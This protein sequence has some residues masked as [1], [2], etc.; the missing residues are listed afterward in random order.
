MG[1]HKNPRYNRKRLVVAGTAAVTVFGAMI[2]IGIY[3][4]ALADQPGPAA[5]SQ[6]CLPDPTATVPPSSTTTEPPPSETAPQETAPTETTTGTATETQPTETA[7]D[8]ATDTAAETATDTTTETATDTA[9]E[10]EAPMGLAG[11]RLVELNPGRAAQPTDGEAPAGDAPEDVVG[12]TG[13]QGPAPAEQLP[14][15]PADA[16]MRKFAAPDCTDKLGPFP[17]D[18]VDI[19]RVRPSFTEPRARRGSSNGTFVSRCGRNENNHNNPANFIVAPGNANGAQHT[20]DY[21]GNVSADGFS[22]NE[23]LA[24][25]GTTCKLD[26]RSTYYWPVVRV[27]ERGEKAD[28]VNAH[29]VGTLQ[30][31]AS[32]T[33]QFRGNARGKVV[34]A[35]EFIRII[36]GDAKAAVNGGANGNAKWGCTRFPN[37][38][39]TKY[40]LCPRGSQVLRQLDFPSC[41]DGVNTDSANHRTHIVFPDRNGAC[42]AGTKAVPA[43][44]MTLTY[45]MPR[46]KVYSLDAF[47]DQLHNPVTDHGDFV[48]VMPASLMD[49]VVKCINSGRRC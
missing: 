7:T 24:A 40:T 6:Q 23:S 37:R 14:A 26:D 19:R 34:A 17:Q 49:R 5:A 46:G 47:P 44:R 8:T 13:Y 32:V 43:L 48:N 9:T 22:T 41:W 25:A 2:G 10:S 15:P 1:R 27:R 20:H 12:D 3:G 29:N 35:P 11:D 33:L 4:S 38:L 16:Q 36:T 18:F 39:T 21:V 42:P 30:K 31:P 45:N 28:E